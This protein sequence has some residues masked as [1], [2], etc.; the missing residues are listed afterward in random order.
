MA[1]RKL[2]AEC[3]PWAFVASG[4]R[5]EKIML[6]NGY[7]SVALSNY[8]ATVLSV[9]VPSKARATPEE[10]TLC[11]DDLSKIQS[12][13][14]YYGA[15]IGRVANRIAR[16]SFNVDGKQYTLATN[17]GENHLHGGLVG[18]DKVLWTPRLYA[19]EGAVGVQFTYN[20]HD[21]EEGYPG[22]VAAVADYR[23]VL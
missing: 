22:A 12:S 9:K 5:A 4:A 10:L 20:S 23:Y 14:P 19:I 8:G 15:T 3:T 1:V 21:G 2:L 7:M 11:Y 16:G 18:W 17:N 13:S 6:T